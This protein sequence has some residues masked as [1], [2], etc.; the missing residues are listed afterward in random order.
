[1]R[2][3]ALRSLCALTLVFAGCGGGGDP[4]PTTSDTAD[5][6]SEPDVTTATWGA[7][8]DADVEE[9]GEPDVPVT[10]EDTPEPPEEVTPPEPDPSPPRS[11]KSTT[12]VTSTPT[13]EIGDRQS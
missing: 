10:V 13:G 1:M 5:I 11:A 2:R 8:A 6:T 9:P 3:H 12:P 7:D 4:A